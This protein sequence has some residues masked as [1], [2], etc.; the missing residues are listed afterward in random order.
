VEIQFDQKLVPTVA[1]YSNHETHNSYAWDK[2]GKEQGDRP[3]VYVAK[4]THA[5]SATTGQF[6]PPGTPARGGRDEFAKG[7]TRIDSAQ[8]LHALDSQPWTN[9]KLEQRFDADTVLWG[10]TKKNGGGLNVPRGPLGIPAGLPTLDT[11]YVHGDSPDGPDRP[12]SAAANVEDLAEDLLL[13]GK[14]KFAADDDH[15]RLTALS[16]ELLTT[17]DDPYRRARLIHALAEQDSGAFGSWLKASLA[18]DLVDDGRITREQRD[19]IRDSVHRALDEK[20]ISPLI[21]TGA[22]PGGW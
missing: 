4:G 16:A 5:N 13:I 10:G 19:L 7:G 3:L 20:L 15:A 2:V 14:K 21:L 6:A 22:T 18:D 11:H 8:D 1:R 12:P 9:R 17:R